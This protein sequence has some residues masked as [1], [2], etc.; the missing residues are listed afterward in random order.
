MPSVYMCVC[1]CVLPHSFTH[2]RLQP[3]CVHVL[4]LSVPRMCVHNEFL[5]CLIEYYDNEI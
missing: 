2:F 4:A 5:R 1:V 3:V